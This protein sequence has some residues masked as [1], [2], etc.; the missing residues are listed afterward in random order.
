MD[1]NE[2]LLKMEELRSAMR[3][4][5]FD[6][7]AEIADSL[8][9]K[10]IKDNNFLSVVADAYERTRNYEDAKKAL[11]LA[12][13]NTNAG[14]L[15]AFK[16][17]LISVKM[18]DFEEAKN[19][20]DDFIEMAPRDTA[21]YI[22][23]YRMSKSQGKSIEE[24]ISILEEY[25]N[26]DME[27]KWAYELAK[28]YHKAGETEKCVDI[29]DEIS[30]WFSEG[31]YVNKA[32]ELKSRHAALTAS[33]QEKYDENQMRQEEKLEN[34]EVKE[35]QLEEK[36][37]E[38]KEE[39]KIQKRRPF[40][41]NP[42]MITGEVL[43]DETKEQSE[44][45]ISG[46]ME[47]IVLPEEIEESVVEEV[48]HAGEHVT[49]NE[50]PESSSDD[51]IAAE[52]VRVEDETAEEPDEILP[53]TEKLTGIKDV[54]DILKQLQER[55]ILKAET[56]QQAVDIIDEAS[57]VKETEENSDKNDKED[58][59]KKNTDSVEQNDNE[60]VIFDDSD[61]IDEEDLKTEEEKNSVPI[62]N[63][64]DDMGSTRIFN[65]V[66]TID[67]GD[68]IE[69]PKVSK[70]VK[71]PVQEIKEDAIPIRGNTGDI[72]ILDLDFEAPKRDD[73]NGIGQKN[74]Y[75]NI[76]ANSDLGYKTDKL[77]TRE[78]LQA[79]IKK[80]EEAVA[81][82]EIE[83]V[84][85]N[86]PKVDVPNVRVK[87]NPSSKIEVLSG[88]GIVDEGE[89]KQS[90]MT[91]EVTDD[92]K[93][94]TVSVDETKTVDNSHSKN[95]IDINISTGNAAVQYGN[96]MDNDSGTESDNE[97]TETVIREDILSEAEL[98][99]FKNY[100]NV[101]GFETNIREVLQELI[102]NYTPNGKSDQ[103]N[104]IIMGDEKTGKTTLAIE[105]VKLV[106]RKRGRRNRRLA[107]VDAGALNRKGF[108]Y[109]VTKLVGSDLIVENADQLG[110]MTVSELIDVSGM[111]T[112]DML[113][114]LEGNIEG[115][116]TLMKESPRLES[117]FNHVVR[118]KEYD[119]KE[120]VEYGKQYALERGYSVD[121]LANLAFYKAIDD[122]FGA[123][124]GIGQ[125]DV[126]G[127]IEK[128]IDKSGRISRKVKGIFGSKTDDEGLI[129]LQESDF[130]I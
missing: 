78:E 32:M 21:R 44:N 65:K 7:A 39:T 37:K 122:F 45:K 126:E 98:T 20:Y 51:G 34:A 30:L 16:L 77:P 72:P 43:P 22:L 33:Q 93:A 87:E 4:R 103:G 101:E 91:S 66:Q 120:W 36:N 96:I 67:N 107:K 23:K 11:E 10:K 5:E 95:P 74:M 119:I 104:V 100:L 47:E 112:D 130:D 128:A 69:Q 99:E 125:S 79:A 54:S 68:I 15:I 61:I 57:A 102:V 94:D 25:V 28:L 97:K 106:N 27:E 35:I 1:K 129:V 55:G 75:E 109:A 82:K 115:M 117:V 24:L 49:E 127:I 108:R 110:K 73:R 118:I 3:N 116:E 86:I 64:S 26:L 17:C 70:V 58:V 19:F 71:P 121:E 113:I 83:N 105:L 40:E 111:F 41:I 63:E 89:V 59:V 14:R 50:Q 76:A 6:K 62:V 12:Y 84:E 18:K 52:E 60:E 80:A 90:E 13:E 31:K 46:D 42:E 38:I 114:V 123:N 48:K 56:V 85:E 81:N 124:K 29:C 9:L 92:K 53:Q 88:A 2:Q 8:E